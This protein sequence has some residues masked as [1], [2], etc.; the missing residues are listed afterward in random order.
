MGADFQQ[1]R[2]PGQRARGPLVPIPGT[3]VKNQP[4]QRK[5]TRRTYEF[6]RLMIIVPGQLSEIKPGFQSEAVLCMGLRVRA[7]F[8]TTFRVSHVYCNF[9]LR[10]ICRITVKSE[11]LKVFFQYICIK[12]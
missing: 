9:I 12:Q 3:Y 4:R 6:V 11:T 2:E 5:I 1:L 7:F 8:D 10:Y